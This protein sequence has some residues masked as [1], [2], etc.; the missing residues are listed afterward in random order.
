MRCDGIP[1]TLAVLHDPRQF[2]MRVVRLRGI[3]RMAPGLGVVSGCFRA[4]L[5]PEVRERPISFCL[6]AVEH[7]SL[8]EY[9]RR[10]K[11]P[12]CS[13]RDQLLGGRS[14]HR[15]GHH[16]KAWQSYGSF[17]ALTVSLSLTSACKVSHRFDTAPAAGKGGAAGKSEAAGNGGKGAAGKGGA[18][19]AGGG[20]DVDAGAA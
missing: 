1:T 2:F 3:A 9:G 12:N 8:A 11:Q 7:S 20:E 10:P 15:R 5:S 4:P 6:T 18:G 16:M 17:L 19:K 13:S 14:G